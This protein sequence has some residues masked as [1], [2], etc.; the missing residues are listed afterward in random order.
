[1]KLHHWLFT[2]AALVLAGCGSSEKTTTVDQAF[3]NSESAV[4]LLKSSTLA[5]VNCTLAG[6]TMAMSRQLDG[7]S[8]GTCQLANG[9]RCDE[10]SLMNGTCPAG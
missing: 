8:V 4:A 2:A 10:R 6:G 1:M 5:D 3:N 9:K 7:A